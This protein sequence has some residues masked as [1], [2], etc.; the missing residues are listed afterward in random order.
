MSAS[1]CVSKCSERVV[2]RSAICRLS[3]AMTLTAAP[4]VAANAAASGASPGRHPGACARTR[5]GVRD[6]ESHRIP[7]PISV[8][9]LDHVLRRRG[10]EACRRFNVL[11]IGTV[12]SAGRASSDL[13]TSGPVEHHRRTALQLHRTHLR[14]DPPAGEGDRPAA[15]RSKLPEPGVGRYSTRVRGVRGRR[16]W[17]RWFLPEAPTLTSV[18]WR[19]ISRQI[20]RRRS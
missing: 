12:V 17:R 20:S 8:D 10:V 3:S 9:P 7:L 14:R 4:V 5:R 19:R 11:T 18:S 16:V 6:R 15:R 1:G 13:G 2:S